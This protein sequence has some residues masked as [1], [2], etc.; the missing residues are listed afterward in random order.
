MLTRRAE[1]LHY[2]VA[3][4]GVDDPLVGGV[5]RQ[6]GGGGRVLDELELR[7]ADWVRQLL[8]LPDGWHVE[9]GDA[10]QTIAT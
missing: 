6:R 5:R 10:R 8:G 7:V 9:A 3:I 1:L 4:F 2:R